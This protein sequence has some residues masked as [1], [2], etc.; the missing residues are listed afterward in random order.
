MCGP[1]PCHHIFVCV[2]TASRVSTVPDAVGPSVKEW[3]TQQKGVA[4]G[5]PVGFASCCG[6]GFPCYPCGALPV[7]APGSLSHRWPPRLHTAHGG[8]NL[9]A[10]E[11][12]PTAD[13]CRPTEGAM[14]SRDHRGSDVESGPPRERC[15]VGATK[16]VSGPPR[17]RCGVFGCASMEALP[18][19]ISMTVPSD[20]A[21]G[22]GARC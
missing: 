13:H 5:E 8:C 12:R 2:L 22:P 9:W 20:V 10:W 18:T 17:E 4:V 21:L 15:G 11:S 16:R 14:W 1:P 3:G 7:W 6:V 19:D